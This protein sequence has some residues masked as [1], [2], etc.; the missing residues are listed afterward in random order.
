M[1]CACFD[2]KVKEDLPSMKLAPP[3]PRP[4]IRDVKPSKLIAQEVANPSLQPRLP[5]GGFR[6]ISPY[7]MGCLKG[8]ELVELNKTRKKCIVHVLPLAEGKMKRVA[9]RT[10]MQKTFGQLDHP[11]IRTLYGAVRDT[12]A[13]RVVFETCET[14]ELANL[15]EDKVVISEVQAALIT[16]QLLEVLNYLHVRNLW[17][18]KLRPE[19]IGLKFLGERNAV[20]KVSGLFAKKWDKERSLSVFD[21]PESDTRE[22]GAK[23]DIWSCGILLHLMLTGK[24]PFEN[25]EYISHPSFGPELKSEEVKALIRDMLSPIPSYRPTASALLVH[26]WL[27][28]L[29]R[30]SVDTRWFRKN[31]TRIKKVHPLTPLRSAI[32][33]FI[34]DYIVDSEEISKMTQ[35][36]SMLDADYDGVLNA[37]EILSAFCQVMPEVQ[38]RHKTSEIMSSFGKD[39]S[40]SLQFTEF[41][42]SVLESQIVSSEDILVRA[43]KILG[44]N[45]DGIISVA[46]LKRI[47]QQ[48]ESEEEIGIDGRRELDW[49]GFR[50]WMQ[51][52]AEQTSN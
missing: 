16:K 52:E 49:E 15:L 19:W 26:P 25:R 31:L 40:S 36:F 8:L 48:Q 13:L 37:E 42:L 29:S 44:A 14:G 2:D 30:S 27:L 24:L 17:H 47:F 22:G 43:F 21:A 39:E 33:R 46:E 6:L 28:R 3:S 10:A 41:L 51:S 1:G 11:H 12:K 32:L 4:P 38:A 5:P 34:I 45:D 18:G 20:I 23:V 35:L 9:E 7:R 50:A